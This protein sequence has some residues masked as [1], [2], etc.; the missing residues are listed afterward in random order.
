LQSCATA[1]LNQNTTSNNIIVRLYIGLS[2][3]INQVKIED[4]ENILGKHFDGAT[5]QEAIGFYKKEREKSLI[6][7]LINCCRWEKP[8]DQF[9]GGVNNLVLELR[10][11]L[12][13]E[14]ILVEHSSS[15]ETHIFEILE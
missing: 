11:E 1:N 15:G 2:S 9:L 13:Q 6:I 10:C 3:N 7:T 12:G 5:L 14:S 4:I 8:K